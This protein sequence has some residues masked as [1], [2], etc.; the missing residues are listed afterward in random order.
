MNNPIHGLYSQYSVFFYNTWHLATTTH[1]SFSK[2]IL[3]SCAGVI[4]LMKIVIKLVLFVCTGIIWCSPRDNELTIISSMLLDAYTLDAGLFIILLYLISA[5][6]VLSSTVSITITVTI[7]MKNFKF[8][9][10]CILP[11][12]KNGFER[13]SQGQISFSWTRSLWH[14]STFI[15]SNYAVMGNFHA[16][17]PVI[18]LMKRV[19]KLVLFVCTGMKAGL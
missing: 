3:S 6:L 1:A 15:Y 7:N 12:Q 18:F 5:P 8:L 16:F 4:F 14:S 13:M 2:I 17:P 10:N 11:Q 9:E 19:I